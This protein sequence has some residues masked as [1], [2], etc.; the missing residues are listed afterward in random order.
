MQILWGPIERLWQLLAPR[1][2][3]QRLFDPLSEVP[4]SLGQLLWKRE[5]R[6]ENRMSA[7]RTKS[8]PHPQVHELEVVG[9]IG[10]EGQNQRIRL[11][12]REDEQQNEPR[13]ERRPR[14]DI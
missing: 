6:P 4:C 11:D 14:Y 10:C 2:S 8:H 5:Q 7:P 1:M 12:Q 13:S 9:V 3:S